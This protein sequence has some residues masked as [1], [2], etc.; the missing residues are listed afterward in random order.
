MP[1]TALL[2]LPNGTWLYRPVAIIDLINELVECTHVHQ[3]RCQ[4]TNTKTT[5]Q[6]LFSVHPPAEKTELN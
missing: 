3:V 1:L 6:Y 5:K 4:D 2:L